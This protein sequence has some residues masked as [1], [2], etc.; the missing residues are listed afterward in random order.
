[1]VKPWTSKLKPGEKNDWKWIK[2][3]KYT[4]VYAGSGGDRASKR[5]LQKPKG[6]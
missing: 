2:S 1:M 5:N 4:Y 6:K 3:N